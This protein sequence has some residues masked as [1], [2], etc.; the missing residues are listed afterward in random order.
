LK[1]I[2]IDLNKLDELEHKGDLEIQCS[3]PYH[4]YTPYDRR[5]RREGDEDIAHDEPSNDGLESLREIA[6]YTVICRKC[7]QPNCITACP[8]EALEKDEEGILRRYNLRCIG[9]RS[10]V[11]ACPFGTI[12][13]ELVPYLASR[14]DHCL[15][16]LKPGEEPLCVRT[17]PEGVV[18]Y[19]EVEED[20]EKGIYKVGD[21]LV[22]KCDVWKR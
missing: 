4:D 13:P 16:R 22:V 21:H 14:C 19:K 17:S 8:K 12:Y 10:C 7:E 15:E 11:V 1:R 20:Q 9:C 5:F 3:Y 2:F 6:T 18:E